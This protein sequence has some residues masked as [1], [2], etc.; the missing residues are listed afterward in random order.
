M[1]TLMCRLALAPL[2]LLAAACAGAGAPPPAGLANARVAVLEHGAD[3]AG[4]FCSDFRLSP[5]QAKSFLQRAEALEPAA[6]HD[7]FEHL[8][9]WVRGTAEWGSQTWRWEIRAGGTGRLVAPDGSVSMI[10]CEACA[11]TFGTEK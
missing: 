10:G 9:C 11:A 5:A 1:E 4:A 3:S 6:L 8:P 7:R 2:A